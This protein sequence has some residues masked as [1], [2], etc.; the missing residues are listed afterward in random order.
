MHTRVS[1]PKKQIGTKWA[2]SNSSVLTQVDKFNCGNCL[3]VAKLNQGQNHYL[4]VDMNQ[5][6]LNNDLINSHIKYS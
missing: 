1:V 6:L 4:L 3:I 5:G 2:K